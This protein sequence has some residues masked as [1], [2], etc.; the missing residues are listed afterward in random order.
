MKFFSKVVIVGAS[1]VIAHNCARLLAENGTR[2]FVLVGRKIEKL[3]NVKLDLLSRGNSITS[4]EFKIFDFLNVDKITN[5][6]TET[7]STTKPDLVLIAHGYMPEQS[8]CE[9]SLA[10]TKYAIEINGVS[11]VLFAEAYAESLKD[12]TKSTI[13]VIG[14]V[15]GDRG[16][17]TNYVYGSG[18]GLIETFMQGLTHRFGITGP[19]ICL[20]KPGPTKSAMTKDIDPNKLADPKDVALKL[21]KG[22]SAGKSVIYAPGK[23]FLIMF[24]IRN[25]PNVI[26]KYIK[27]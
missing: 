24:V 11:P 25:I 7:T 16:R 18:K 19:K 15:A 14:S 22:V 17:L 5:L 1:S 23:W 26:F 4:V 2:E 6:V 21:L 3:E 27:I 10:L 12:S 20:I 9:S 8:A 13:A